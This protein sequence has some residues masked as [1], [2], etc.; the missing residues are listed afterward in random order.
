MHFGGKPIIA[1]VG[2]QDLYVNTS[3]VGDPDIDRQPKKAGNPIKMRKTEQRARQGRG[4]NKE[5][6]K[7]KRGV[8][9]WAHPRHQLAPTH[10]CKG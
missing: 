9:N 2:G 7:D 5:S 8:G 3:L 6:R 4:K 1:K 10:T